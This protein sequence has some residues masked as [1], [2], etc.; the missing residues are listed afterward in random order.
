MKLPELI[1]CFSCKQKENII[2][3]LN[4]YKDDSDEEGWVFEGEADERSPNSF[5]MFEDMTKSHSF[6]NKNQITNIFY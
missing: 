6:I 4:K 1:T 3:K 5:K 2:I